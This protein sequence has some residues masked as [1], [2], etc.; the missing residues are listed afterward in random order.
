[1]IANS[2]YHRVYQIGSRSTCIGR[3]TDSLAAAGDR[4]AGVLL[5]CAVN[6][7][8]INSRMCCILVHSVL[9]RYAL[10][11]F[12]TGRV[13]IVTK[14]SIAPTQLYRLSTQQR[15]RSNQQCHDWSVATKQNVATRSS[16]ATTATVLRPQDTFATQKMGV[17]SAARR[18][19]P[20]KGQHER[21]S[22]SDAKNPLRTLKVRN[23]DNNTPAAR[24]RLA[25]SARVLGETVKHRLKRW[26][27]C[28]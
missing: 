9:Y 5:Q 18:S 4:R 10:M 25:P 8:L 7:N 22:E 27:A 28:T 19:M 21:S 12:R 24:A 14:Y 26:A 1:M 23:M 20:T 17:V 6:M 13:L 3:R 2:A 16:A 11:P 15:T